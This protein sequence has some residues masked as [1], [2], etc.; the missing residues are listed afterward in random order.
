M[1]QGT[2]VV[3]T[4][5]RW[6][7]KLSGGPEW[8]GVAW[9]GGECGTS[10]YWLPLGYVTQ[11]LCASGLSRSGQECLRGRL[12]LHCIVTWTGTNWTGKNVDEQQG[13]PPLTHR[14]GT[15]VS[16]MRSR[17][18]T[19]R[20]PRGWAARRRTVWGAARRVRGRQRHRHGSMAA[21]RRTWGPCCGAVAGVGYVEEPRQAGRGG[22]ASAASNSS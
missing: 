16:C 3:Y 6:Q 9:D 21:L 7:N 17:R 18:I 20:P 13:S 11:G 5:Q 12:V 14:P 19:G 10:R 8:R 15:W 22:L 4:R 2:Y 1:Q